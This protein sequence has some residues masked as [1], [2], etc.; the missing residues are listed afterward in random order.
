MVDNNNSDLQ[1]SASPEQELRNNNYATAKYSGPISSN[2]ISPGQVFGST[3]A[4]PLAS[5]IL[6]GL[7]STA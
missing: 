5:F 6:T 2:T 3:A 4:V 1:C 7:A